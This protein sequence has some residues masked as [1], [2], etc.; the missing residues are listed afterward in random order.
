MSRFETFK[1]SVKN[2]RV[3]ESIKNKVRFPDIEARWLSARFKGRSGTATGGAAGDGDN[4]NGS[5]GGELGTRST[6]PTTRTPEGLLIP[7]DRLF[8]LMQGIY[9][10]YL[11][12]AFIALAVGTVAGIAV[13]VLMLVDRRQEVRDLAPF[14]LPILLVSF[15]I[16]WIHT[17]IGWIG[18]SRLRPRFLWID[19][20]LHCLALATALTYA[21]LS[22]TLPSVSVVLLEA[23]LAALV[24]GV[25]H[26]IQIVN[27]V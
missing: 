22:F 16:C 13:S 23:V 7:E 21:Y 20:W 9:K 8:F 26:E 1:N 18:V 3:P 5:D 14:A 24:Y 25:I 12:Q 10:L 17:V 4:N 6:S 19:L 27:P 15:L 11:I 2:V